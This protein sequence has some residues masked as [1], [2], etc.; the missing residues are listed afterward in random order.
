MVILGSRQQFCINETVRALNN[1]SLMTERCKE[2]RDN[3]SLVKHQ[4]GD[5]SEV[6]FNEIRR[7]A[8]AHVDLSHSLN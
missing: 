6:I 7:S 3:K 2:L 1:A 4:K 8:T 5:Q